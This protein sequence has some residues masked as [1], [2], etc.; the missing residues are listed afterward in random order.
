M[1][2]TT[3]L[4][5]FGNAGLPS[6]ANLA[7][8]LRNVQNEV[9]PG[10]VTILKM[11]KTGCWCYGT[12]SVEVEEGSAWAINPFSFIHG[13]IA[14]GD[15][16]VLAE[17]MAA[18]TAPMPEVGAAPADAAKGWEVQL[19]F[20]LR[21]MSG[22][23]E[24]LE[25]RYTT[26]S[27]GGKRYIQT[28]AQKIAEQVEIDATH[29]VPVVELLSEHYQHKKYGKLFAPKLKVLNWLDMGGLKDEP[30]VSAPVTAQLPEPEP[31]EEAPAAEPARRRRRG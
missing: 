4:A 19:G 22:D 6:A 31:E 27:V 16:E 28:V 25:A 7:A 18:I 15:G 3:S 10:G 2:E 29:P 5:T 13:Y 12:D 21:C 17:H 14:W 23:D 8:A 11:D 26:T 1:S 24:G 20:M 30:E 9:G